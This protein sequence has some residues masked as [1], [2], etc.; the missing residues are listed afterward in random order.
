MVA[1]WRNSDVTI[2]VLRMA[3]DACGDWT[4]HPVPHARSRNSRFSIECVPGNRGAAFGRGAR[5]TLMVERPDRPRQ[6]LRP[7]ALS[8]ANFG[9]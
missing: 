6:S 8:S 4:R 5:Q 1:D 2:D 3:L 7:S 9:F